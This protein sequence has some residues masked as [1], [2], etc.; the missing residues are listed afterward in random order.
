MAHEGIFATSDECTDKLGDNYSTDVNEAMINRF[1]LQAESFLNNLMRYNLSD[2]Y[3]TL[4]I[5]VKYILTEFTSNFVGFYGWNYKPT[6]ED[7]TTE[8][9]EYEDRINILR[10]GMMRTISLLKDKKRVEFIN[11]T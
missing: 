11:A 6:G 1:C 4:N 10:D 2:T 3:A 8:R 5:D 9:I 7:G